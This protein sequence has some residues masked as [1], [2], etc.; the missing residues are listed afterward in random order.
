MEFYGNSAL[1][2]TIYS[3]LYFLTAGSKPLKSIA[4]AYIQKYKKVDIEATRYYMN[5]K[6][7]VFQDIAKLQLEDLKFEKFLK[8]HVTATFRIITVLC[9]IGPIIPVMVMR[10]SGQQP[11][12]FI[13]LMIATY[14]TFLLAIAFAIVIQMTR[15][16][17]YI[18][19]KYN[20]KLK[21]AYKNDDDVIIV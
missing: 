4:Y 19:K 14:F 7:N 21:L 2:R 10:T 20:I 17:L 8:K 12:N 16:V 11:V 9:A 3:L 6:I 15:T 1:Y 18:Q 13:V 5:Q